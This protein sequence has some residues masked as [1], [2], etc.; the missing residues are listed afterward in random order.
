MLHMATSQNGGGVGSSDSVC[1]RDYVADRLK[2]AD[3]PMSPAELADE[4]GC[5][6][7]HVRNVLSDLL[8]DD[9]VGR[10][11]IGEYVAPPPEDADSEPPV[12]VQVPEDVREESESVEGPDDSEEEDHADDDAGNE[13]NALR[14]VGEALLPDT[15]TTAGNHEESE[16]VD[17]REEFDELT[18]RLSLAKE[19]IEYLEENMPTDEEYEQFQATTGQE[20]KDG[21]SVD[22][23]SEQVSVETVDEIEGP[24]FGGFTWTQ[25]G[26]AVA[27][28][29]IL[30]FVYRR[31]SGSGGQSSGGSQQSGQ[32]GEDDE[33]SLIG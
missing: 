33:I 19:Q 30:W 12:P 13:G 31:L 3:K 15:D 16:D 5:S 20:S 29:V 28:L 27:G 2:D 11:D 1:A 18:E 23:G 17:L 7:G 24:S 22:D 32:S 14:E 26:A 8:D 6:N 9:K 21:K 4:Y 10:V 25:I